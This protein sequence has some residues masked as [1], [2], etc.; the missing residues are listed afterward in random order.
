M[1]GIAS[2]L[3]DSWEGTLTKLGYIQTVAGISDEQAAGL[4][5]VAPETYRRWRTDRKPN[6]CAVRLLGVVAG[7]VPWAGWE[8]WFYSQADRKLYGPS[9]REGFT[10]SEVERIPWL[11]QTLEALERENRNL[12]ERVQRL[13]Q[14]AS[15]ASRPSNVIPFPAPVSG[16][17]G[18]SYA[19]LS[20]RRDLWLRERF[21]GLIRKVWR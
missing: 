11:R 15:E 1:T 7:Y 10:P 8:K 17:T 13:E 2:I 5:F 14:V 20:P 9:L 21:A 3:R 18:E 16:L 4:C 6:R 12:R 19:A